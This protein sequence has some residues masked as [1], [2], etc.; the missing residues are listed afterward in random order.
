[1]TEEVSPQQPGGER[2]RAISSSCLRNW[3]QLGLWTDVE[4]LQGSWEASSQS[5]PPP[6][7]APHVSGLKVNPGPMEAQYRW[8][9]SPHGAH[10]LASE[11]SLRIG[12]SFLEVTGTEHELIEGPQQFAVFI[13]YITFRL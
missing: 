4:G 2:S 8:R 11:I 6:L 5:L 13:L 9:L 1:M 7:P 12:D 3:W 10:L